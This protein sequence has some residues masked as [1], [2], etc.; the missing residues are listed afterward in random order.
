MPVIIEVTPSKCSRTR[1][2]KPDTGASSIGAIGPGF[3]TRRRP[4]SRGFAY[5]TARAVPGINAACS[6][7]R[8]LT[9]DLTG[10][11]RRLLRLRRETCATGRLQTT[12]RKQIRF[13][14]PPLLRHV[15]CTRSSE[16]PQ[17]PHRYTTPL[18]N[19]ECVNPRSPFARATSPP[20]APPPSWVD[21]QGATAAWPDEGEGEDETGAPSVCIRIRPP[22]P[23]SPGADKVILALAMFSSASAGKYTKDFEARLAASASS[24]QLGRVGIST[25][26]RAL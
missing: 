16:K 25:R 2:K 12:E 1:T 23:P 24:L 22:V 11:G 19:H 3:Q 26:P 17:N 13:I 8:R 14:L 20:Y 15:Q 7:C 4:C 6:R 10:T 9:S 18:C 21:S 5:D